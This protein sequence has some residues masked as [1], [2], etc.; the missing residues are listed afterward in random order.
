MGKLPERLR[1]ASWYRALYQKIEPLMWVPRVN[2]SIY[3]LAALFLSF[4]FLVSDGT[5]VR[6]LLLLVVIL[7]DWWDGA[8]ARKYGM[9]GEAGYMIDVAVDR[10]SEVIMFFPLNG[11]VSSTVWFVLALFN[12]LLSFLSYKRGRHTILPL[13]FIY[14]FYLWI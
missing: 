3:Q 2:P 10:L 5:K 1:F 9:A 6:F 11:S 12:L 14:L 13:R 4:G 7:L 8:T